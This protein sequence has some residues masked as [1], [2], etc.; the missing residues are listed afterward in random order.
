[1]VVIA[2]G[3]ELEPH[4]F[5]LAIK[6][7]D[8]IYD[9]I[10]GRLFKLFAD[11]LKDKADL[12]TEWKLL[13]S[14]MLDEH[15][16]RT[17]QEIAKSFKKNRSAIQVINVAFYQRTLHLIWRLELDLLDVCSEAYNSL[18]LLF[19]L[20]T[21]RLP[22]YESYDFDGPKFNIKELNEDP[23]NKL[24]FNDL[25]LIDQQLIYFRALIEVRLFDHYINVWQKF[26]IHTMRNKVMKLINIEYHFDEIMFLRKQ[27]EIGESKTKKL[28]RIVKGPLDFLSL[29]KSPR[30]TDAVDDEKRPLIESAQKEL[31]AIELNET[32]EESQTKDLAETKSVA[33][34]TSTD[35]TAETSTNKFTEVSPEEFDNM[36]IEFRSK[37]IELREKLLL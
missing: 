28:I 2:N 14:D 24:G 18:G 19:E 10:R 6:F 4:I 15:L 32:D 5:E 7:M 9:D 13:I 3:D 11:T 16:N 29:I 12:I 34:T 27:A 26:K 22:P 30:K 1:M 21:W 35:E 8:H 36:W 17:A 31:V 37:L 33:E 20:I 25:R 23:R